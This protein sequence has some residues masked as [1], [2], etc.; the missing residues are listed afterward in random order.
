MRQQRLIRNLKKEAFEMLPPPPW[1]FIM[2]SHK[3]T[4]LDRI[5]WSLYGM[6]EEGGRNI[7]VTAYCSG[8]GGH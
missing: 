6:V 8:S 5:D 7:N 3:P 1:D 4:M 2:L